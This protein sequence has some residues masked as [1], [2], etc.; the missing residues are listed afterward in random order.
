MG[1]GINIPTPCLLRKLPAQPLSILINKNL[2]CSLLIISPSENAAL[3][4]SE[5]H[6]FLSRDQILPLISA[7]SDL[8]HVTSPKGRF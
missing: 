3:T 2:R 8:G 5:I 6:Q 7:G 4:E 1:V